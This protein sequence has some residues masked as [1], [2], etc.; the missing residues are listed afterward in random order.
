MFDAFAAFFRTITK[1]FVGTE[2]FMDSYVSV[3]EYANR[4]I[5][6]E[7]DLV[8]NEDESKEGKKE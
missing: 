7:L 1:F 8:D 3:A 4:S 6:K 2:K 5:Q